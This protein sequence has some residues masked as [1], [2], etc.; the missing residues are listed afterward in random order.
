MITRRQAAQAAALT[1]LSYSRI[2]GA[3]DRIGLGVIGTGNRGTHV[4]GLFQK[5][6]EVE[7]RATA[8]TNG[9]FGV[10]VHCATGRGGAVREILR[11][12]GAEEVRP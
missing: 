10:A 1:A 12:A 7:V 6:P 11:G 2:R 9:R 4:M 5:N 3:N 8:F